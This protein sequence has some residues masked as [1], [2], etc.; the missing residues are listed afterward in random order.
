MDHLPIAEKVDM[1]FMYGYCHQNAQWACTGHVDRY[2]GHHPSVRTLHW[3]FKETGSV[4]PQVKHQPLPAT[5]HD[6]QGSVLASVAANPHIS[7][8]QIEGESG[9]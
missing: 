1:V 9:I 4:Q 3:I 8:R 2:P 5:N 6:A 7:S